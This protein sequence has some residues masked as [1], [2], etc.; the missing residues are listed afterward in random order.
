MK[1]L[2]NYRKSAFVALSSL[3]LALG[4]MSAPAAFAKENGHS[5][6]RGGDMDWDND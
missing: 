4:L 5:G 6:D 3:V 2:K 1:S